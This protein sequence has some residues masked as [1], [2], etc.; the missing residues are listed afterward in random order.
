MRL[1]VRGKLFLVSFGLLAVSVTA[2]ES[3][4]L[5]SV[6]R[7]LTERVRQDLHVRL[8]LVAERAGSAA[9]AGQPDWD[10]LADRL[11]D[12]AQARVTFIRPD[13]LVVGDSEVERGQLAALENHR[14][15]PEVAAA[16]AGQTTDDIRYSA[17]IHKRML[18]AAT[19]VSGPQTMVARLSLP[20]AWVDG[21]KARTRA[22]LLGGAAVALVVAILLSS[23]AAVV[24]SRGL[25]KLTSVARR[26]AGG[27]LETRSRLQTP[28]ELG[29]LGRALDHLAES[30]S[31]SVREL[32]DDRDLLGRILLS[33]R[34]GVLV[35]DGE[36]RIL[37]ANPS[38]RDMLVLN[39]DVVG[40]ST[41]EV[42]RNAELQSIVEKALAAGEPVIGEIEVGGIK[43]RRLLVHAA[44]LSGE[45]RALL[46]VLFDV[47]EMRRL[48][49]IRRDFVANVSHELRTPIASLRSAAET[50]RTAVERDA[51]AAAQFIDIIER[52]G[53]RLGELINDL[54][55]LSKIEAREFR[56]S[57]EALDVA[58]LVDKTI[59][60]FADRAAARGIRLSA[61]IPNGLVPA[62]GDTNAFDR[63]LTN[64]VDNALK[65]CPDGAKISII[66]RESS[67]R[68]LVAVTDTG[69]GIEERH[70]P[71]LFE[72][73]YRVD[74]GRSRDMG[75]TGLG[76]SIVKHLV[77]AM[78]G[79]VR[80]ESIPGKGS[81]FSFSLPR[82]T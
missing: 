81:T 82:A 33:M 50:L 76:L 74:P 5:P 25:R 57:V 34:E 23:L 37:L 42:I 15:R 43:P 73:F 6:E 30:L 70:L 52:N 53:K 58:R 24:M 69:P 48:E 39:S 9:A 17:T 79:E 68:I 29:E 49:T 32:R 55:D 45:P 20:L 46:L 10:A 19:S 4:L 65:Y 75:G 27:D 16:L 2:A 40:H 18:Y 14:A 8:Q 3:Y 38:L 59:A 78:G 12:I 1:G 71:R 63:V 67:G 56:L 21:A 41:M 28:D 80:V 44:R 61:E 11:G 51:K 26:M 7:D 66:A 77:E 36:H 72:R 64:L 13:G 35:M 54:L 60:H 47:T 31:R 22:L 62:A